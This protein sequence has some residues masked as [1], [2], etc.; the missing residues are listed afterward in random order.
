MNEEQQ[1]IEEWLDEKILAY[2]L[3]GKEFNPTGKDEY[4]ECPRCIVV[5]KSNKEIHLDN[6]EIVMEALTKRPVKHNRKF[7]VE[8]KQ[9]LETYF[10]YRGYKFFEVKEEK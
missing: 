6:I 2:E 1:T 3:L 7:R 4:W 8:G 10:V 5:H 9:L